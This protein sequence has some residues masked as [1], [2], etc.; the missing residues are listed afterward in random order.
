[1]KFRHAVA[2]LSVLL[3]LSVSIAASARD[4][5]VPGDFATIQGAID[6]SPSGSEIRV[7]PGRYVEN[8]VI[9]NKAITIKSSHGSSRTILDG[10][11]KSTTVWA[12]GTGKERVVVAGFK[13]TNGFNS[14]A[15][16]PSPT[17][18]T[19]GGVRVELVRATIEDNV[20]TGNVGCIGAGV[21]SQEASIEVR[22]NLISGNR[23][24][25]SCG[26]SNGGGIYM[27]G[28]TRK[29][30]VIADNVVEFHKIEGY[31]G[32]VGINGVRGVTISGNTIHHNLAFDYGGGILVNGS[33][34]DIVRN[35]IV[36]NATV[37]PFSTTGG[38]VALLAI[39]RWNDISLSENLIQGNTSD[40]APGAWLLAYYDKA[41]RADS[42]WILGRGPAALVRCDAGEARQEQCDLERRRAGN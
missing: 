22:R 36:D 18:G 21:F 27:N 19:G 1:M 34:A 33:S 16:D 30:S 32:G 11:S 7:G 20:I 42:N 29:D 6:A 31:G 35:V 25:Q 2:S 9:L 4:V 5:H 17:P 26:G 23:Q 41:I 3:G 15:N 24:D 14:F 28:S 13:I 37:S 10:G 12:Q 39:D 40:S 38:G 8:L